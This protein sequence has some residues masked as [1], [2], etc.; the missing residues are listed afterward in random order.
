MFHEAEH[1]L[2]AHAPEKVLEI[3]LQHPLDFSASNSLMERCERLVGASART[4]TKRARQ[5]VLLIDGRQHLRG[6]SLKCPVRNSRHPERAHLLLAGLR[7]IDTPYIWRAISLT[8][9][10]LQHTRNP[11][12]KTLFRLRYG[13]SIHSGCGLGRYLIKILPNPLL[14]DVMGQRRKP[15]LRFTPSFDCYSF[16]SCCHDW[17]IFSLHR[18]PNPPFGWSSCFPRTIQLPLAASPRT[19]LSRPQSTNSQ[20]DCRQV[21]RSSLL[22]RLVGPYKLTLEPDGSPLFP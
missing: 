3:R 21:I 20:S 4:A 11:F 22:C 1:P 10:R 19:R 18:S 2:M 14:C 8:V 17:L 13:L 5:K 12:L 16:E 7:D 15:K 6:A 9:D